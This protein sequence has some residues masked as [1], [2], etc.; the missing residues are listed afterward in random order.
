MVW[1][2][3]YIWYCCG[4]T[5]TCWRHITWGSYGKDVKQPLIEGEARLSGKGDDSDREEYD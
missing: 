4:S 1:D 3:I 5:L 2:I